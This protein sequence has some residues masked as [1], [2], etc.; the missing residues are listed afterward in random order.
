MKTH[1]V[2][3]MYS[4][5]FY[6]LGKRMGRDDIVQNALGQGRQILGDFYRQEKDAIVEF[7]TVDGKYVDS[8]Q[9]RA[10]VPGHAL[11]SMWFLISIFEHLGDGEQIKTCCRLITRH[12][13]LGW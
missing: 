5:F 8:P 11:E 10:C 12:L 1:G 6:E 9:G 3:M 13:E 2:A 4:L 7:V